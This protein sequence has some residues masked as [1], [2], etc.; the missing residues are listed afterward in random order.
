MQQRVEKLEV[1]MGNH[2]HLWNKFYMKENVILILFFILLMQKINDWFIEDNMRL[3]IS[4]RN[5]EW[6]VLKEMNILIVFL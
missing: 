5:K 3:S 1:Q 6:Y 4:I 2:D